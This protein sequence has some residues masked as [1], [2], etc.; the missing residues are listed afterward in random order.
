MY[1]YYYGTCTCTYHRL[2]WSRT[3]FLPLFPPYSQRDDVSAHHP[4]SYLGGNGGGGGELM[5]VLVNDLVYYPLTI[6]TDRYSQ[7]KLN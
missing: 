3:Q 1:D 5:R 7:L 2:L 6:L 4:I